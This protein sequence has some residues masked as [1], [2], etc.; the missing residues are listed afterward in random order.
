MAFNP[1]SY[2]GAISSQLK[3][4]GALSRGM[5]SALSGQQKFKEFSLDEQNKYAK[6][7][8]KAGSVFSNWKRGLSLVAG[9]A[10][11]AMGLGPVAAGLMA[12]VGTATGGAIGKGKAEKQLGKSKYFKGMTSDTSE[13]MGGTILKDSLMSAAMAY[14]AGTLREAGATAREAENLMDSDIGAVAEEMGLTKEQVQYDVAQAQTGADIA[15]KADLNPNFQ[16]RGQMKSDELIQSSKDAQRMKDFEIAARGGRDGY[17]AIEKIKGVKLQ[18]ED[19][20]DY[21][22][23]MGLDTTQ[24]AEDIASAYA[25]AYKIP[26]TAPQVEAFQGLKDMFRGGKL[27]YEAAVG[28]KG[29][30]GDKARGIFNTGTSMMNMFNAANKGIDRR[31]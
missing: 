3:S 14:G 1:G 7:Q 13:A 27:K 17:D 12:G 29:L 5:S 2:Q 8:K 16:F 20:T 22:T 19:Y 15:A 21:L 25:D 18:G 4:R 31:R 30:F 26:E 28:E 6:L 24:G 10:A 23:E 11:T 9:L